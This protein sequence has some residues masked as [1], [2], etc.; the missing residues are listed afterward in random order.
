MNRKFKYVFDVTQTPVSLTFGEFSRKAENIKGHEYYSGYVYM[1]YDK[2]LS[3]N[4]NEILDI[5][6]LHPS[7]I[8]PYVADFDLGTEGFHIFTDREPTPYK[9]SLISRIRKKFYK[10]KYCFRL[11]INPLKDIWLPWKN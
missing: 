7:S 9:P 10:Y 4:A 2:I 11:R 5:Y 3:G 6:S 1:P 8:T